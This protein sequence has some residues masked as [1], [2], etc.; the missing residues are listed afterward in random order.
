[1]AKLNNFGFDA[2]YSVN[3]ADR[4]LGD[5]KDQLIINDTNPRAT[6]EYIDG[7]RTN[8]QSGYSISVFTDGVTPFTVKLPLADNNGERINFGQL[9]FL[10]NINFE[11]LEAVIVNGDVFFRATN[12]TIK[13]GGK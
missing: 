12:F 1:M 3:N 2:G 5:L 8:Q 10:A 9:A 4:L 13:K 11:N 6:F 7:K